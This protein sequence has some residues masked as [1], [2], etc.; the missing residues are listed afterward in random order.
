MGFDTQKI[1][2][3]IIMWASVLRMGNIH[4]LESWNG[5]ENVAT[6]PEKNTDPKPNL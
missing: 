4:T 5:S 6:K 2:F 1:M 3:M